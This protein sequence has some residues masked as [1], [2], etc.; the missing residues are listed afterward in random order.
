MCMRGD[1]MLVR[2]NKEELK[3]SDHFT[4]ERLIRFVIPS[5]VMMIFTSIYGV[6]DGLFVSNFVGKT[7]FAALNLIM[8]M[9]MI[10]GAVGFMIGTGG[11]A[12]VAKTLGEGDAARAN[13]YFTMLIVFDLIAGVA[14]AVIGINFQGFQIGLPHLLH[15]SLQKDGLHLQLPLD[16]VYLF[17]IYQKAKQAICHCQR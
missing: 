16:C 8:P 15:G 3:L 12:L 14:L 9:I 5:I 6:V 11:S 7:E 2:E 10:L 13:R 17:L 4:Y 1:R